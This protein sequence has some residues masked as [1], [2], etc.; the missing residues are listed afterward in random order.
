M[1]FQR[2]IKELIAKGWTQT[3][4]ANDAGCCQGNIVRLAKTAG[5]EPRWSTGN[6]LLTMNRYKD[7]KT[8]YSRSGKK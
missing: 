7:R 8:Y 1:D 5:A 2:V 4:I 6:A 3:Q